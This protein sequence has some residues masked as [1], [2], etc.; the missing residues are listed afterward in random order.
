LVAG[1]GVA[2]TSNRE[3]TDSLKKTFSWKSPDNVPKIN[4]ERQTVGKQ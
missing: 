3:E 1:A 2:V 4:I